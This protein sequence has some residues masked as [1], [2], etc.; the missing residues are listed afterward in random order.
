MKEADKDKR[1]GRGKMCVY[2]QKEGGIFCYRYAA[3]GVE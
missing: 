3:G 1:E 2:A